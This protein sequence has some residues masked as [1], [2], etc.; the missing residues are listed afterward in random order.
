MGGRSHGEPEYRQESAL[1]YCAGPG[2]GQHTQSI[3][4]ELGYVPGGIAQGLPPRRKEVIG[5]IRATCPES[6][7]DDVNLGYYDEPLGGVIAQIRAAGWSLLDTSWDGVNAPDVPWLD[8]ISGEVDGILVGEGSLPS[9]LLERLAA[10]VPVVIIAG[11]PDTRGYDVV[12]TDN[13]ASAAAVVTHLVREHGSRRLFHLGGPVG[14][15][16]TSERQAAMQ[17]VLRDHPDSRLVGAVYGA[18]G[19]ETGARPAA[20]VLSAASGQQPDA[21]V[22][23]SDQMAI[24]LLRNLAE[25]GVQVPGDV[26]VVGFGDTIP[27]R[28]ADPPLTTVH[29]PMRMLGTRACSRLLERI[30]TRGLPPSVELLASELVIRSSCGCPPGTSIREPV[31]PAQE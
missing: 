14:A 12:T 25:A 30:A 20:I 10:R 19:A 4:E 6:H 2:V 13:R 24:G 9:L 21:I 31:R 29:Q 8:A 28:R 7:H 17:Q 23:A 11:P 15:P 1:L 22:C 18:F 16:D 27:G 26:A 3:L 5:V